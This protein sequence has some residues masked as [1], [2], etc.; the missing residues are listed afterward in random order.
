MVL[1]DPENF[2]RPAIRRVTR[3]QDG[4]T[5][6]LPYECDPDAFYRQLYEEERMA[7]YWQRQNKRL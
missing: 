5:V 3:Q 2:K 6:I 7:E 4:D 1:T